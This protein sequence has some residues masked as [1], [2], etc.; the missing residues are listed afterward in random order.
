MQLLDLL[1][2]NKLYV[3]RNEARRAILQGDIKINDT[4]VVNTQ[5]SYEPGQIATITKKQIKYFV[6]GYEI[7]GAQS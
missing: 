4:K 7:T 3:T 1:V 2:I 6:M 5:I